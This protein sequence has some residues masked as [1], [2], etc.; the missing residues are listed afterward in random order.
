MAIVVEDR[1]GKTVA[2]TI[3][4]F[5]SKAEDPVLAVAAKNHEM[6]AFEIL[7]DRYR[8]R[9]FRVVQHFRLTQ[10]DAEDAV[11]QT[12]HKALLHLHKFEGKSSF[13]TWLTRIAINEALMML[14][15]G[16]DFW[17]EA[18]SG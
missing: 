10:E 2:K 5:D 3:I 14:R 8:G 4:A 12:F 13:S 1:T 18:T 17:P 7:V 15:R 11:Q 9:I 6:R 16:R